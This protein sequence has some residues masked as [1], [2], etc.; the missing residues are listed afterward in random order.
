MYGKPC[1]P[2][3]GEKRKGRFLFHGHGHEESSGG[4]M[5]DGFRGG[6]EKREG[7]KKQTAIASFPKTPFFPT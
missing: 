3:T 6:K 4:R 2:G 1:T 7:K 5:R